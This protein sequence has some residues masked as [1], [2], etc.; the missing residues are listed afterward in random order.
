[1]EVCVELGRRGKH[2]Q[3]RYDFSVAVGVLERLHGGSGI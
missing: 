2:R 3:G 1:M